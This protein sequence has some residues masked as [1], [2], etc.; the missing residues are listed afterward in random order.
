MA[1]KARCT[2]TTKAG[3]P[4]KAPPLNGTKLCMSHSPAETRESLG[5]VADNGKGGRKPN[6]RA[7][8]VL[9][10][11]LEERIDEVLDPLFE[12]LEAEASI[13]VGAGLVRQPDHRT[14]ITAVRELLD[15]VYGKPKQQTEITGA[16]GGPVEIVAPLD[17][18]ERSARAARLL[19]AQGLADGDG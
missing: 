11:R 4:C 18:A 2:A 3:T 13:V 1:G 7:V 12:A 16:N 8:D 10:E 5:F 15:R 9:R 19:K 14:R 17:A 6:P